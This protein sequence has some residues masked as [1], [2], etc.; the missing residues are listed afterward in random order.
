LD[1]EERGVKVSLEGDDLEPE[2]EHFNTLTKFHMQNDI[3]EIISR[4]R[5]YTVNVS[6]IEKSEIKDM[7]KLLN[8]QNYDSRFSIEIA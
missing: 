4:F 8:K 3:I 7:V 6:R 1:D 2:Q 5:K